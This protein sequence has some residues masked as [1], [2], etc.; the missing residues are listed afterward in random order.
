MIILSGNWKYL[1]GFDILF[2]LAHEF[3]NVY[4]HFVIASMMLFG[5]IMCSCL[6]ITNA[7]N[8]NKCQSFTF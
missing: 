4:K 2:S 7:V 1:I 5:V 6:L 3:S 8:Y